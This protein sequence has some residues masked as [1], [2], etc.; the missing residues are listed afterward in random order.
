MQIK[1]QAPS[2]IYFCKKTALILFGLFSLFILLEFGLRLGGLIILSAQE[3]KNRL[4]LRQK[5]TCRIMCLGE[6]TTQNHYPRFL[7]EIL[8]QRKTGIKFSVIDKGLVGTNT[9]VILSQLEENLDKYKPDIVVAMMGINDTGAYATYQTTSAFKRPV[10]FKSFRTYKLARLLLLH[11]LAKAQEAGFYISEDKKQPFSSSKLSL[12]D[13]R[14]KENFVKEEDYVSQEKL[15][16]KAIELNPENYSAYVELGIIYK[17]QERFNDAEDA[18]KKAIE[19]KSDDGRA[20]E[21]LGW[22]YKYQRRLIEAEQVFKKAVELNPDDGRVYGG[23]GL[24]YKDQRRY[25]EAEEVFKKIIELNPDDHWAYLALGEAYIGQHRYIEAEQVFKKDIELN[26]D[27]GRAYGGL[28]TVYLK[29]GNK[30]LFEDY[31]EKAGCL[32]LGYHKAAT[33][34]NYLKLKQAL[35]QRNVRLVCAQYPMRSIELLKTIFKDQKGIIFV[36]NKGV[37]LDVVKKYGYKI[38]FRDMF[39]GDFGHCTDKGYHLLAKN[40]GDVILKEVFGK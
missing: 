26:F 33:V 34:N 38:Y 19:L 15:A 39:A 12:P 1:D 25:I 32:N 24:I 21:G 2:M 8:N 28:E 10:F 20:Y 23:L 4:S 22:I 27:D 17:E 31:L 14:L 18:F 40:I 5:G 7:E 3:Q 11:I 16:K 29:T 35:D 13:I 9:A 37:F 6:S 36:D 30:K